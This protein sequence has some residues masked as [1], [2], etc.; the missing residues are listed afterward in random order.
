[1]FAE[2]VTSVLLKP[3]PDAAGAEP[4]LVFPQ[5]FGRPCYRDEFPQGTVFWDRFS[6][7]SISYC[8][9]CPDYTFPVGE[10]MYRSRITGVDERL[11]VALSIVARKGKDALLLEILAGLEKEGGLRAVAAGRRAYPDDI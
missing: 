5:A 4:I 1:M 9:G 2:W 7:Y 8:S 10:A 3:S 6:I 11:P